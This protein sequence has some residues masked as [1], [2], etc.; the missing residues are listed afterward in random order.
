MPI[1]TPQE[2]IGLTM[3]GKYR[4]E[5][6]LATGGMATVFAGVH[7]WTER[8]VAVKILNYEHAREP[9][10]VRRFLQEARAAAQ[11]KH[12]NVVDVLDMGED[13]DGTVYLVLERLHGETLK[14]RIRRG[15]LSLREVAA[16]ILPVMRAVASAHQKGVVHRD[17]KPDNIFLATT[18]PGVIVPKLLDFG[19]AKVSAATDSGSTRTGLMVGTPS[20][21]APEQVRGERDVGPR[22]DVWSMGVVLHAAITGRV[23]FEAESSAAVLARVITERAAPIQ[24]LAPQLRPSVAA[25]ID[26]ALTFEAHARFADM[27]EMVAALEAALDGPAQGVVASAVAPRAPAPIVNLAAGGARPLASQP[28]LPPELLTEAPT[29]NLP[30]SD[31]DVTT[32]PGPMTPEAA[33]NLPATT[34]FAWAPAPPPVSAPAPSAARWPWVVGAALAVVVAAG[35]IALAWT[36]SASTSVVAAPLAPS[37]G[38][39]SSRSGDAP[40]GLR[41]PSPQ[42][43]PTPAGEGVAGALSTSPS[44]AVAVPVPAP[45]VA[46]IPTA[47]SDEV[48]PPVIA[49]APTAILAPTSASVAVSDL[50]AGVSAAREDERASRPSRPTTREPRR[51]TRG[52]LILH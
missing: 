42:P 27:G 7:A 18:E 43:S 17:I 16:S 45:V 26:R 49:P 3:A 40:L 13:T 25:V 12:P 24:T 1:L 35:G 5:S 31:L 52:S 15:P 47:P 30:L 19:I 38:V 22:A 28:G 11:L 51:G 6:I 20:Y 2:R 41:S 36:S 4:L 23:P 21:M 46:P 32:Q 8:E 50:D 9:E 10:V 34:P 44:G 33:A 14:A 39:A 48:A 37:E 29:V